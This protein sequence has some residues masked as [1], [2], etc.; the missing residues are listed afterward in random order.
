[1]PRIGFGE[2]GDEERPQRHG[3]MEPG[4]VYGHTLWVGV[5]GVNNFS[6]PRLRPEL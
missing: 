6:R 5:V 1:V 2:S 3:L 4:E